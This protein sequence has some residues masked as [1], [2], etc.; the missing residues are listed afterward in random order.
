[1]KFI[2]VLF[3]LILPF[4]A[5]ARDEASVSKMQIPKPAEE[6]PTLQLYP[7]GLELRY[8]RGESQD[9]ESR[10]FWNPAFAIQRKNL[11]ALFEYGQYTDSS[12]SSSTNIER[13]HTE[14]LVWGR[15]HFLTFN[16]DQP[17]RFSFY[18][19][20]GIGAY[21]EDITTTFMG[22]SQTDKSG[23]KVMEA[24]GLGGDMT[25]YFNKDIALIGAVE[26][27]ALF[28]GDFDPNPTGSGTARIGVL[29][30]LN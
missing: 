17:M 7:L 15:W 26:A 3:S 28:S 19:G 16:Q 12:N 14:L 21:Q 23:T 9:F 13:K 1:M 29:F 24:V 5:Q 10:T 22:S 8:E 18:A 30:H 27:R 4:A 25:I 11:S 20:L 2:L 6:S